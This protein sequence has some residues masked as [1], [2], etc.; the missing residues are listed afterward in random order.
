MAYHPPKLPGLPD[1]KPITLGKQL[2]CGGGYRWK[3]IIPK[4]IE[5]ENGVV[6]FVRIDKGQDWLLKAAVGKG[7][8]SG[9]L[10]RTKMFDAMKQ[11]LR[12]AVAA[13]GSDSK[14]KLRKRP[15]SSTCG[16]SHGG[17]G[18]DR[19]SAQET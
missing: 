2:V 1:W 6:V 17:F 3:R 7:A 13:S 4:D 19:T 16:R 11:K 14:R 18:C 15:G 8:R 10:M 5:T 12:A 9:A